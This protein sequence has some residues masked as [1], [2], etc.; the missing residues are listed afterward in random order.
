MKIERLVGFHV[1]SPNAGEITQGFAIAFKA[2]A[3]KEDFRSLVGIH[4]T[5]AEVPWPFFKAQFRLPQNEN[6]FYFFSL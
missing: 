5:V 6:I 4:P 2:K 3:T 1:L